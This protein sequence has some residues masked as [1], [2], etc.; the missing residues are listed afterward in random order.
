MK[1]SFFRSMTW[2]HTWGGL[3]ACWLLF[4]VFLAGTLSYFRYE[5]SW[6]MQPE[7]HHLQRQQEQDAALQQALARLQAEAPDSPQWFINLPDERNPLT[8]YGYRQAPEPGQRRGRFVDGYLLGD[9]AQQAATLRDTKGGDF[10]YRLHFDLHYMSAITARWIVGGAAMIMLVGLASGIVIHRRIFADFFT[11][12]KAKGARSWLDIHNI[13]SV[14]ALPYHLMITYT[15]LLTLM[16]LYMPAPVD[17]VY[18]GGRGQFFNDQ[19][20]TFQAVKA[21]G[22]QRSEPLPVQAFVERF[23]ADKQ[24]DT[25]SRIN[26]ANPADENATVTLYGREPGQIAHYARSTLYD[27]QGQVLGNSREG[28]FY[29]PEKTVNTLIALHTAKFAPWPLRWLFVLGGL[30]GCVMVASGGVL[31]AKR[32]EEKRLKAGQ[33]LGW[34]LRLVKALN[35]ATVAGLPLASLVFLYLNRLLAP[36]FDA[37]RD[38]EIHG[39]F[40]CYVATFLFA[41]YQPERRGW[42]V[43]WAATAALALLLPLLN[44]FTTGHHVQGYLSRGQWALAALELTVMGVGIAACLASR[45]CLGKANREPKPV[46]PTSV[47]Q[48][49]P[50]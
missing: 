10:F 35:I 44:F 41:L 20:P 34:N 31:W 50:Q 30:L 3:L 39:F 9:N 13:S 21:T 16:F 36:D 4:L 25:I 8:R 37:R 12:R 2:L 38:W 14:L 7:S 32:L 6:W 11:F 47:Y 42:A 15:G 26:I 45:H 40:I 46:S 48:E 17:K 18:P 49:Q 28:Q 23:K 1:G 33:S 5:I 43:I 19:N 27:S 24:L 29:A 22:E